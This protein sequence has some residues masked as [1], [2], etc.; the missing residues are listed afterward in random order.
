MK[1]ASKLPLPADL[2]ALVASYAAYNPTPSA[3]ALRTYFEAH[4]WIKGMVA[5]C[6]EMHLGAIILDAPDLAP[7]R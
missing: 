2:H 7:A 5:A 1:M 3:A 6:P 4:P